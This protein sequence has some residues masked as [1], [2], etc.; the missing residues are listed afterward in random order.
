MNLATLSV[1]ALALAVLVSCVSRLNVGVLSVALAW[2]IG[3][4]FAGMTANERALFYRNVQVW[5]KMSPKERQ[6]WRALMQAGMK[7]DV[8]WEQSAR[9]YVELYRRTMQAP[10]RAMSPMRQKA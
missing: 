1:L 4:Y 9:A 6:E 10:R 3:V 7:T 2:I 5:E 8:S